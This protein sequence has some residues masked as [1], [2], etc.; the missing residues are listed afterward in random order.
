MTILEESHHSMILVEHDI[1]IYGDAMDATE[2][3]SIAPRETA[4]EAAVLLY[5]PENDPF[6][7]KLVKNAYQISYFDEGPRSKVKVVSKANP[8]APKCQITIGPHLF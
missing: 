5:V 8:R 1:R 4:M 3:I 6:L 2:Y 7:I